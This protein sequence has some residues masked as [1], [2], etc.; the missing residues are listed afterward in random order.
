[1][2]DL[3]NSTATSCNTISSET[4][5]S[6][7]CWVSPC[8]TQE[9]SVFHTV[10]TSHPPPFNPTLN[11][12]NIGLTPQRGQPYIMMISILFPEFELLVLEL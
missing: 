5:K 4:R 2:S 11:Y 3:L 8:G 1:M 10:E 12:H 9:D 6:E 7:I